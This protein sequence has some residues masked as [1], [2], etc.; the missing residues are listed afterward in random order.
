[1]SLAGMRVINLVQN[2][3]I[4]LIKQVPNILSLLRI[5]MVPIVVVLLNDHLYES[6]LFVFVI[7]G[8]TDGV[9]GFIA[10][11]FN[12]QSELGAMLDPMAD[13][14]LLVS[15]YIM[16]TMA[17]HL[18]FWLLVLVIFRDVV[19]IGGYW[20]L[21]A[22]GDQPKIIPSWVSKLNT[23]LQILLVIMVLVNLAGWLH[24]Q[25]LIDFLIYSVCA[26]TLVSGVDYVWHG[27]KA[28]A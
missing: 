19:I 17:N 25:W 20:M 12:A 2:A 9:D 22:L 21:W 28:H 6:A 18:P 7:A 13:K 23:L 5:G 3:S 24:M 16:L 1:M 15:T 10:K 4:K 14:L 11:R 8:I 27:S 26:T